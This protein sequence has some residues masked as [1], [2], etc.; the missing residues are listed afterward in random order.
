MSTIL[1]VGP[2]PKHH[3]SSLIVSWGIASRPLTLCITTSTKLPETSAIFPKTL[4]VLG[5]CPLTSRGLPSVV[6]GPFRLS[7]AMRHGKFCFYIAFPQA[8]WSTDLLGRGLAFRP[9]LWP[10]NLCR[11]KA[12]LFLK[13]F[14]KPGKPSNYCFARVV[15]S[16]EMGSLWTRKTCGGLSSLLLKVFH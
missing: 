11:F 16:S 4:V 3:T 5:C 10:L 2:L 14:G 9:F 1:C 8:F 15:M 6:S 12:L 13:S 7:L